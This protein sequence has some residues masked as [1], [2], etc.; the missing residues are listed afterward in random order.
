[1]KSNRQILEDP[2]APISALMYVIV[3]SYKTEC[4]DWE[5]QILRDELD[6]DFDVEL[7][8]HQSDKI[9][10]GITI[11]T[12]DMYESDL[13][14]FEV[15]SRLF[16]G[17]AQDFEDFEPLEAEEL[18]VA[19]TEVLLLKMEKLEFSQAVRAYAGLVFHNYGFCKAPKLFEEAI[20]PEGK[21]VACADLE[22]NEALQELFDGKI[23]FVKTYMEDIVN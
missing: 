1:M 21:P 2:A 6:K 5:P 23:A 3:K 9:Q 11:L 7:T 17:A 12:T 13:R 18:I 19:L 15:C 20:I 22:K 4:F 10:A 8:D 14:T 16:S